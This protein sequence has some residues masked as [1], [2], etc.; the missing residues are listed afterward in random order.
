MLVCTVAIGG[1]VFQYDSIDN[2]V[3]LG[4]IIRNN[5]NSLGTE[6]SPNIY[7]PSRNGLYIE[8]FKRLGT[9]PG[10]QLVSN[11]APR[12]RVPMTVE[13]ILFHAKK[14]CFGSLTAVQ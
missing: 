1:P 7:L 9:Q 12:F 5:C 3:I 14:C 11:G 8:L 13:S 10:L 4:F 6:F 2:Q